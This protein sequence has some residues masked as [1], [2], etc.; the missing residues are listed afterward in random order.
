MISDDNDPADLAGF[1]AQRE[2]RK[3]ERRRQKAIDNLNLAASDYGL[4]I[5][6]RLNPDIPD[7]VD[8][9]KSCYVD[10]TGW[11]RTFEEVV[12]SAVL[13]NAGKLDPSASEDLLGHY[14]ELEEVVDA[15]LTYT[16]SCPAATVDSRGPIPD[17][18]HRLADH[19]KYVYAI[20][21]RDIAAMQ[22]KLAELA[23]TGRLDHEVQNGLQWDHCLPMWETLY[24][25]TACA[26]RDYRT[27]DGDWD[28]SNNTY[29]DGRR[30]MAQARVKNWY[31]LDRN[32]PYN[33]FLC[34]DGPIW[35]HPRG[36]L[37]QIAPVVNPDGAS[38]YLPAAGLAVPLALVALTVYLAWAY[39]AAFAPMLRAR[40]EPTPTDA[41][42]PLTDARVAA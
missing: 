38:F 2:E 33:E 26:V 25:G 16:L 35:A 8:R 24:Y 18:V 10:I 29:S 21:T 30:V 3:R 4:E 20:G 6:P 15:A 27:W 34:D 19:A 42:A 22:Y 5:P 32:W 1:R 36:S 31:Q 17:H 12:C 37:C 11:I 39:R 41:R 13:P 9:V 23:G 7:M 28:W 40:V 14:R